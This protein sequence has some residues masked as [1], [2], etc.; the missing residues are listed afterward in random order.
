LKRCGRG[1]WA[2]E[3]E[4]KKEKG[5]GITLSLKTSPASSILRILGARYQSEK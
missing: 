2:K 3:T 4:G 1:G 5:G